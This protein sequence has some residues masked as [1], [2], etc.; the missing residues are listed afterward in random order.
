MVALG[1]GLTIGQS[2]D[3]SRAT[4]AS[5]DE[6]AWLEREG[7]TSF[8]V[9]DSPLVSKV[10]AALTRIVDDGLPGVFV[11]VFDDLWAMGEALRDHVS[12]MMAQ[13]YELLP[14][15]WA[16]SIAPG[17]R[18]WR[19]HRGVATSL[20]DR[21]AP[22][23]LNAWIALGDVPADRSCIH[24]VPL[25]D[26]PHYPS[27]LD[28]LDAPLESARAFPVDAGC[29]LVWNANVLHWGG[30]CSPR[31]T[32][33]RVSCSFSLGRAGHTESAWGK[34]MSTSTHTTFEQRLE[35]IATQ[36][37]VY[38]KDH[39]KVAPEVTEWAAAFLQL[40]RHFEQLKELN[41]SRKEG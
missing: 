22:E 2:R 34:P 27:S 23:L 5:P 33:P 14:D 26:D 3:E 21:R 6:A 1:D 32:T 28:H 20:F 10:A 19:P 37:A 29:A 15:L 17:K 39:E 12:R 9:T 16:W 18:G 25:D 24:A 4:D 35:L 38:G 40:S 7:I 30:P 41:Q 31:T 13:R 36:I 8:R 11:Y